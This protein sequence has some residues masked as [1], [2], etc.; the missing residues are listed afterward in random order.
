MK[1]FR[2]LVGCTLVS[3]LLLSGGAGAQVVT[4]FSA[5]ISAGIAGGAGP[6]GIQPA[7]TATCGSRNTTP[8]KIGRINP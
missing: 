3:I 1:T 6:T 2:I 8:R 7:R 5:G 4:E